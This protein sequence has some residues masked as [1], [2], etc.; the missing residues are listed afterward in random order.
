MVTFEGTVRNNTKGRRTLCLDYECYE[1]MALKMMAADRPE[2]AGCP[3]SRARRHGAPPGPAADRRDQRRRDR[4]RAAPPPGLRGRARR[5]QPPEEDA[6][7]SGRRST[8]WTAKSGWKESGIDDVP[9]RLCSCRAGGTVR[10]LLLAPQERPVIRVDVDLVRVVA[11]VKNHRRPARRRARQGRLRNLRQRSQ[12]GDRGLRTPDRAAALGRPDDRYQR[13]HRQG[14]EVR[15]RFRQRA[16]SRAL[17]G[18]GNPEDM[19]RALQ[20]Q[21]GGARTA[22]VSRAT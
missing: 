20:L 8:S 7:P 2:I 18:E 12:A 21:L 10:R 4:H 19:A 13:L 16:S 5:H 11:T 1:S 22:A 14:T 6:S 3:R 9:R 17:L 15:D